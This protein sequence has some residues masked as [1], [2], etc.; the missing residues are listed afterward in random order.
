MKKER[1]NPIKQRN[2][3]VVK[4]MKSFFKTPARMLATINPKEPDAVKIPTEPL[5]INAARGPG[6]IPEP[7]PASPRSTY[8][9]EISPMKLCANKT[10]PEIKNP[11]ITTFFLPTVSP[12]RPKIVEENSTTAL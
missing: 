10:T 9:D 3:A 8:K 5:P 4:I 2:A 11:R 1:N 7:I 12:S 6:I